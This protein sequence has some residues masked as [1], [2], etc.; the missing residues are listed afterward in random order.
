MSVKLCECGCGDP[1]PIAGKTDTSTGR[2]AGQPQR[3]INGHNI[4]VEPPRRRHEPPKSRILARAPE[5]WQ[6]GWCDECCEWQ[7]LHPRTGWCSACSSEIRRAQTASMKSASS[8][9]IQA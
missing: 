3:F 2:V 8:V 6:V 4:R 9:T 1:A 5:T 7:P